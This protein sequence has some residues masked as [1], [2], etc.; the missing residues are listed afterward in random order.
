MYAVN[1][2]AAT[3]GL[4]R[5]ATAGPLLVWVIVL[6]FVFVECA[7]IIG[8]F[9]P[10]DSL[11]FAAGVVLAQHGAEAQA[12]ALSLVALL[13]AVAGNQVGYAVGSRTGT[14]FLARR[15]GRVLNRQNLDRARAFLDRRGFLA[16]VAARWLPWVRTLAPLVAGAAGMN[17]RRFLLATTAGALLWVPSLVLVGFYAAELLATIPWLNHALVWGGVAL[18]VAGTAY[19]VWR[20]RQEMGRPVDD[21]DPT[22]PTRA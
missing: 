2:E 5:L 14:R 6:G 19:G 8:L 4:D 21:D 7:L 12:W 9:L 22:E 3:V 17:A 13:T 1:A 20:Y 15:G 16:I 10:G 11:L 18:F